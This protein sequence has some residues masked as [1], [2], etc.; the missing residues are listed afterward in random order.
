M[1]LSRHLNFKLSAFTQNQP[2]L[3]CKTNLRRPTFL[4][5]F[6]SHHIYQ[7]KKILSLLP[8]LNW[9]HL[10]VLVSTNKIRVIQFRK[11]PFIPYT[12]QPLYM[13]ALIFDR[14]GTVSIW[15]TQTGNE[16]ERG[17]KSRWKS[18]PYPLTTSIKKINK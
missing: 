16:R 11:V 18:L 17:R 3:C 8:L 6:T 14:E 4:Q 10:S 7:G 12:I 1:G 9:G 2:C 13:V 15:G 5:Y